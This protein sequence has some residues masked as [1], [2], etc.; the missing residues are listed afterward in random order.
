M[1]V[2]VVNPFGIGDVLFTTPIVRALAEN[3]HAVYFWSNE[4]VAD[5]LKYNPAIKGL[6]P[7]SRGDLK[8]VFKASAGKGV[9]SFLAMMKR[10]RGSRFDMAL[11]FSMDYRYSLILWLLGVKK[12]IGFDYKGRGCF[13]TDMIKID[14]FTDKYIAEHYAGILKIVD[15]SF[16]AGG[17]ME[18][19]IGED[20]NKWAERFLKENGIAAGDVVVGIAPGGGASWGGDAFRKHWPKENFASVADKLIEE[21]GNKVIIFGNQN[22]S[23]LCEALAKKMKHIS[24][25]TGGMLSLGQFA[26]LLKRCKLLIT[27]DGGPLHMA[28]ALGVKTVSIF[29][30]VDE[31]VYGPY[32]PS[33]D[34]IAIAGTVD[35][36]PCYKNFRYPL[37]KNMICLESINPS[38]VLDAVRKVLNDNTR[39]RNAVSA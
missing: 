27:N 37:C 20:D 23:M 38:E 2:L 26:A 8:R 19:F 17:K 13:L 6:L 29:G 24:I 25:N 1:N 33:R 16:E 28:V 12:R 34:H 31:K 22:E 10:I 30:P 7:L 39:S 21:C 5:I 18:L 4:R 36:R 14:G 32:P 9:K 3:G 35:C 15:K 11:D